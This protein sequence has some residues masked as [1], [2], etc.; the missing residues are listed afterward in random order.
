MR[1]PRWLGDLLGP[2]IGVG[3]LVAVYLLPPD[4]SFKQVQELG[5]LR[6]CVPENFP[7]LVVPGEGGP[8]I[9]VEIMQRVADELGV[10]LLLETN[11]NIGRSFN[12]RAWRVTR[13]QCLALAGGVVASPT[14][15]SFMET[16][17]PHLETGWA[18]VFPDSPVSL[19][20]A[21]VGVFPAASGLDRIALSRLLRQ[22]GAD[23]RIVQNIEG[24][25]AGLA[26]GEFDAG[27]SEALRARSVAGEQ[28]WQVHWLQ[29]P[30][31]RLALAFGLWKGDLTLKRRIVGAL[32]GLR[33]RGELAAILE[34][35]DI[36]PIGDSCSA[37]FDS[38][39]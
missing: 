14:T 12:P 32:E 37:C 13:A 10:R 8:G 31:Q 28:G 16:T 38:H 11:A 1:R 15:R 34:R 17:P 22:Q 30:S 33:R 20:G 6:V 35:Y 7:P 5:V 24:F 3:L 21:T 18:V 4:T 29:D 2:L 39:R 9:D 19:Q 25:V 23:I 27:I 26:A 36:E